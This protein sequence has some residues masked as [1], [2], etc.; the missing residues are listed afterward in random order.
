MKP[1]QD[2]IYYVIAETALAARGSPYIETLRAKGVEVL[3]LSDRIDEWVMGYLTEFDGK[4]FKDVARGDLELGGLVDAAEKEKVEAAVKEHEALL[5]RFK[6]ALGD[7][8]E[9]VRVSTRLADS[10]ACLVIGDH[11]LGAQMR[12]VYAAAGQQAPEGRPTLELNV[13]H[14]LVRR[15]DAEGD[16]A[17][18]GELALLVFDQARL[19]ESGQIANPGEFLRRLNRLLGELMP[20]A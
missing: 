7:R 19:A 20:A 3:L 6:E 4:R 13:M 8:V 2:K 14:P 16:A 11:D 12:R 5:K 17:R 18:A 10:P 9:D 15:F 1:G